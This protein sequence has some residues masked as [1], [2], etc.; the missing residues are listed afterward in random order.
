MGIEVAYNAAGQVVARAGSV[1]FPS[2]KAAVVAVLDDAPA[3]KLV[4]GNLTDKIIIAAEK[5]NQTAIGKAVSKVEAALL[6]KEAQLFGRLGLKSSVVAEKELAK[7][8]EHAVEELVL[9]DAG[10]RV[11][12]DQDAA[13][14]LNAS[15]K[16]TEVGKQGQKSAQIAKLEKAEVKA[17]Q[18]SNLSTAIKL[19]PENENLLKNF[20]AQAYNPAIISHE[21]LLKAKEL[22]AYTEGAI[23]QDGPLKRILEGAKNGV[24]E[25]GKHGMT[26]GAAYELEVALQLEQRGEKIMAFGRKIGGREFDIATETKLIECKNISWEKLIDSGSDEVVK[27]SINKAKGTFGTQQKLA[28]DSGLQFYVYSRNKIPEYWKNW[29]KTKNIIFFED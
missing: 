6:E 1:V 26:R 13:K 27:A 21:S 11:K 7:Q 17:A 15:S 2:V 8:E 9:A 3:L 23:G 12:I 24:T 18:E 10:I 19:S 28:E 14:Q 29:F 20:N 5:I 4:L 22:F 25:I 16:T